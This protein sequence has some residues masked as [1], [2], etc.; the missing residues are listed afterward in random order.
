MQIAASLRSWS[1]GEPLILTCNCRVFA[2]FI[3]RATRPFGQTEVTLGSH[4]RSP[5]HAGTRE[6]PVATWHA[7]YRCV[8][9]KWVPISLHPFFI[10]MVKSREH[11]YCCYDLNMNYLFGSFRLSEIKTDNE[12]LTFPFCHNSNNAFLS[13][14]HFHTCIKNI[15]VCT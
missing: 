3:V 11:C 6:S 2:C 10:E 8:L 1:R 7:M 4:P 5:Y 14:S 12:I 9:K 15:H 13:Q